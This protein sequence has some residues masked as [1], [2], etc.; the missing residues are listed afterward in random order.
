MIKYDILKPVLKGAKKSRHIDAS[1][2][3]IWLVWNQSERILPRFAGCGRPYRRQ[4][5]SL[6]QCKL[7]RRTFSMTGAATGSLEILLAAASLFVSRGI[8]FYIFGGSE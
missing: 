4:H 1:V 3:L 7:S 2:C 8:I 6:P 5:S